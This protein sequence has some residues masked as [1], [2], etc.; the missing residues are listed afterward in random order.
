MMARLAFL[1]TASAIAMAAVPASAQDAAP[2][3]AG[4]DTAPLIVVTAQRREEAQI[5][6]PIS[7]TALDRNALET[8]N[9]TELSDIQTVSPALRFDRQSQFV[10]PTIRGIGT[11]ITTAGGGSNVG[12]YVDNFYSPNPAE[13][14]FDLLNVNSVQVLKGPQGT[15][16]GRNTTGG[17]ILVQTADPSF[18][19][20]GE[21]RASYGSFHQLRTQ[22]YYS[23]G[24]TENIAFDVEGGYST[25]DA[26]QRNIA[27]GDRDRRYRNWQVRT[28]LLF[29][30]GS[31][32]AKARYQH[33]ETDDP[34]PLLY[35]I[36]V[37][38]DLGVAAPSFAPAVTY[39]TDPDYYA[40]GQDRSFV[41][42]NND[43]FQL[44]LEADL[45]F[46][47]LA[48]FTQYREQD[49]DASLDLDKTAITI[50]QFGLPV[51]NKTF[52]QEFLLTSKPGS[53]LQYTAGLFYLFNSDRYETYV[54]NGV[55]QG[56]GRFR[57]GGS[58]APTRSYAAFID[59]T[60]EVTPSL[61]VTAGL[62][63]AHDTIEDAYYNVGTDEFY[64]DDVKGDKFTPR[65]VVRYKPGDSSSIYASYAKGYKAAILDVGGSCQNPPDFSCNDI[66]PEDV[67]AF[68]LG[69]KT[70][71]G[72]LSFEAAAFYYDYKNLQV[73]LFT[74]DGRAAIINAAQSEIYGLEGAVALDLGSGFSFNAGGAYVHGRYTEFPGAPVYTPCADFGPEAAA[75]CAANGISYQAVPTDL[76]DVD[77]QRT[78]E[79][80]GNIGAR[81]EVD[82]G[83][84][85]LAL[86]GNLYYTSSFFF[87]PSGTQFKG[88]DYEVLALRG[89]WSD[90]DD[91]FF[92]ALFGDNVTDSRYVNQVQYNSFAMGATWSQPRSWGVEVGYR[93]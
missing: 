61:F 26:F 88:G 86:S 37:D 81:Y 1:F 70:D 40:P 23:N 49:V 56:F 60:Y 30:F 29:D 69:F 59:A 93:Y 58:E 17:A 31:F 22:A 84:G 44:T 41:T 50:F 75:A 20:A 68:E 6:V 62:R 14:D 67:D 74:D 71:N 11:S 5:D 55:A 45:G 77:M 82:L 42:T 15:L 28:G 10:Q 9:V 3:D 91:R 85:S 76:E 72:A 54:D 65:L 66:S 16:F 33:V 43:I 39:T 2:A 79:F 64:V 8:A 13:A 89:E 12:I 38:D 21:F 92:V 57:L 51:F 78:P 46:A 19:P 4:T 18:Q 35:N 90:P 63:Y 47:D 87:G 53:P 36:Y 32:S 24:I 48:S 7:I 52:T 34:R 83:G 25:G 27:T 80:T 73:S